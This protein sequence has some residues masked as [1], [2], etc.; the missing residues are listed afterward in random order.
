M[1]LLCNELT[2]K[3]SAW[4]SGNS[5]VSKQ[6]EL[7]CNAYLQI[8]ILQPLRS[9]Y[10]WKNIYIILNNSYLHINNSS[11]NISKIILIKWVPERHE[12]FRILHHNKCTV[13]WASNFCVVNIVSLTVDGGCPKL[14]ETWKSSPS[15]V[16]E[17]F[18]PHY[19]CSSLTV[20]HLMQALSSV[21][22]ELG[23]LIYFSFL[24]KILIF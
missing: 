15:I 24:G 20:S 13:C 10:R 3:A 9:T 7:Q 21:I 5:S 18:S 4:R 12:Q 14:S 22:K 8:H 19:G 2:S 17:F 6:N 16:P 11:N 1:C 23:L